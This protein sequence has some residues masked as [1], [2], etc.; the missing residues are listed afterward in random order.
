[1][2]EISNICQLEWVLRNTD[3]EATGSIKFA[4]YKS[5]SKKIF[6]ETN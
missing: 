1:M 2:R 6:T 4:G 5:D 3:G